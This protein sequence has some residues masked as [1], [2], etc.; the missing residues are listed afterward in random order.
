MQ[1][2]WP[3]CVY[4]SYSAAVT[5]THDVLALRNVKPAL[6]A[7]DRVLY[8]FGVGPRACHV[9]TTG[10]APRLQLCVV[11]KDDIMLDDWTSTTTGADT[12]EDFQA[13]C[14]RY[15][16]PADA[17]TRACFVRACQEAR[18]Y[19]KDVHND[20]QA[21]ELFVALLM[22]TYKVE[23]KEEDGK[24]AGRKMQTD[25][26]VA[27]LLET[28]T[29]AAIV[30]KC[31]QQMLVTGWETMVQ[32]DGHVL[33]KMPGTRFFDIAPNVN[34][35]DSLAKACARYLSDWVKTMEID[36]T[37]GCC[38]DLTEFLW[39][40]AVASG[41]ESM[42]TTTATLY[43]KADT[44][45]DQW[46]PNVTIFRTKSQAVAKY[47]E[48]C[49]LVG[50]KC[51]KMVD[52]KEKLVTVSHADDLDIGIEELAQE[53]NKTLSEQDRDV[54]EELVDE[55]ETTNN[56]E[57][58]D[59]VAATKAVRRTCVAKSK[60]AVKRTQPAMA[61]AKTTVKQVK[62]ALK[63]K[64]PTKPIPSFEMSFGKL[65]KELKNRGWY[66][67]AGGLQWLYYQPHCKTKDKS[68][69]EP[70]KDFF[71]GREELEAYAYSSGLYDLVRAKLKENHYN[72]YAS[73]NE[74]DVGIDDNEEDVGID[75]NGLNITQPVQALV[76]PPL[77][78]PKPQPKKTLVRRDIGCAKSSSRSSRGGRSKS[79]ARGMTTQ[80]TL[81]E[82]KFGEIWRVL[83][84][85]GWHY[86]PGKLE[87]DYFKPHCTTTK[88]GTAG[89]DFFQS[90]DLLVEYLQ[91]SGLWDKTAVRVRAEAAMDSSDEGLFNSDDETTT[92]IQKRKR[93]ESTPAVPQQGKKY[94]GASLFCTPTDGRRVTVANPTVDDKV[95]D[96]TIS[97]DAAGSKDK[98]GQKDVHGRQPLRNLSNSFTPTSDTT[99][100]KT[101]SISASKSV[102]TEPVKDAGFHDMTLSAVQKLTS[103]YIP[104]NFRYREKE[105]GE[106][107]E[108]F[109]N[110]FE[111]KDRTSLYISGA[112]GCGKTAL[113][114]STKSDIDDLYWVILRAG[115][116]CME[117]C[118]K[119]TDTKPVWCHVNA[120]ALAGSS[121]LFCKLAEALTTKPFSSGSQAFEAI[122]RATTRR[123]KTSKTMIL[124]L[125]EIDT[126][127]NN[128]GTEIDMCRLFELAHR[129]SHSFIL[130]GIANQVDFTERHLPML[131]QRL[132]DCSPRVVVFE[133][134][135]HQVIEQ[136]L[137]DRLGGQTAASKL[138]SSH[139]VSFLARKIASTTGDIRLA[140]DT[141]RR[142]LQHKLEQGGKENSENLSDDKEP[143][144]PL[145]LT[146][147]LRII[148]HALESKSTS[149]IRS[150]P[151]N[152]QMILF[153][154]TRL[155]IVT[156]NRA[157]ADGSEATPLFG[158]NELYACYCEVSKDAG[159][160]KPLSERD[161]KTALDT[162]GKE[163][164]IAEAELRKHLIKLLFSTSE[165]LQSFRQDA[166]F[167]RL[168]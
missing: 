156:A 81:A 109:R 37:D 21:R 87:Y 7:E 61:T 59:D 40:L 165:L 9:A 89:V 10:S 2:Y 150:L 27:A 142:V 133:P 131:K 4:R 96:K 117:C 35:F 102:A 104:T 138:V 130:V 121:T 16:V 114:K 54:N 125:D 45:F 128:N 65:E 135:K 38:S 95:I 8:F 166:F 71:R 108:F 67:K 162:L 83:S 90:K 118:P 49:G 53:S 124:I 47:L 52:K 127:L 88:D 77:V 85:D 120:M 57:L 62:N 98:V 46:V 97:P 147:M 101:R 56:R 41:W 144:R 82:V 137:T 92:P 43:K 122:E 84:E 86:S 20:E 168:V 106:I 1:V 129:A 115:S 80:T 68:S 119:Q 167:S 29:M 123:L 145:P 163:G 113:L 64:T 63:D 3:A 58:D 100:K 157:V 23:K 24:K 50:S 139:G 161:F 110:N 74:E 25:A 132:P 70:N 159:V 60:K 164:L 69:L 19:A 39:P 30:A 160:F 158:V 78:T 15:H 5:H 18:G 34:L 79:T 66:W 73:D 140:V 91:I 148:K 136:I 103:A 143:G 149:A 14:D 99:T 11:H 32:K 105:F 22:G 116:V 26:S 44:P 141:C 31:W 17:V 155:L 75:D 107:C 146:D 48:A 28:P 94:K 72:M 153:A 112:P 154:S 42:S 152:L 13:L 33:Y 51:G 126:L 76:H 6:D 134:Y 93:E 111:G 151:R 12:E 55:N 36:A